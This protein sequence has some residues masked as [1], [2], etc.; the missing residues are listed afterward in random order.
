MNFKARSGKKR[1]RAKTNAKCD[2]GRPVEVRILVG[3]YSTDW[4]MRNSKARGLCRPCFENKSDLAQSALATGYDELMRKILT[5]RA[6]D[7]N[8]LVIPETAA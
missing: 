5:G 4:K 3:G 1:G 7:P 8:Q 2:C 6:S